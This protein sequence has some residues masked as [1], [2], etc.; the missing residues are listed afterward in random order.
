MVL[1]NCHNI[2]KDTNWLFKDSLTKC[3]EQVYVFDLKGWTLN[4]KNMKQWD[5]NILSKTSNI[6]AFILA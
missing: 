6:K 5:S 4:D 2:P 1:T 3:E